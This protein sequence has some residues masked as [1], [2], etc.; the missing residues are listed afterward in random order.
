MMS[1]APIVGDLLVT[2]LTYKFAAVHKLTMA[3]VLHDLHLLH[4]ASPTTEVVAA[5]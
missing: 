4:I 2:S 1:S 3:G 5:L